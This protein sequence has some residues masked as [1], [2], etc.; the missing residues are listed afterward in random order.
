[1]STR[2]APANVRGILVVSLA[3][4]A[5][6][7]S[8]AILMRDRP[9]TSRL[10]EDAPGFSI[11][12][13]DDLNFQI[14]RGGKPVFKLTDGFRARMLC[15]PSNNHW[16]G[17]RRTPV[18]L[19]WAPWDAPEVT[20]VH[21]DREIHP[22]RFHLRITGVKPQIDKA[23]FSTDVIALHDTTTGRISYG[24]ASNLDATADRVRQVLGANQIEY[25]DPWIEGIFW[26]ERDGHDRE[27][28]QS[29]VF[30][31]ANAQTL[32]R[33]PKLHLFP[34]L[35]GATYETLVSPMTTGALAVVDKSEPGIRFLVADLTGPGTLG[36][37]WWTW[38]PHFFVDLSKA[39]GNQISYSMKIEEIPVKTGARMLADAKPIPFES[40]PDYQVPAFTRDRV[41]RFDDMLDEPGEWSWEPYSRACSIDR[42]LGYDDDVSVTIHGEPGKTTAW[43]TRSLGYDYFDHS[44]LTGQQAV[45]AMVRTKDVD[46]VS[47]IG[48]VCYNGAES[49]LYDEPDPVFAWSDPVTGTSDWQK[50]TVRFDAKGFKRFKIVLEQTGEGV[51]WFDNVVLRPDSSA[52]DIDWQKG[53][54]DWHDRDWTGA[55]DVPFRAFRCNQPKIL[56]DANR[57][58][59]AW[60]DSTATSPR[61]RIPKGRYRL[62]VKAEGEGCRDDLPVL[63]LRIADTSATHPIAIDGLSEI[64]TPFSSDGEAPVEFSLRFA[65]DGPCHNDKAQADKTISVVGVSIERAP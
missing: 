17:T 36:I 19:G 22:N 6:V 46:N 35:R 38:D 48:V 20:D 39:S 13:T 2:R 24:I 54:V 16:I 26:P 43:Y 55:Q 21:V 32:K 15:N 23:A 30:F 14:L 51:S 44:L 59:M 63:E 11:D 5:A 28:Y 47:R 64:T 4:A 42:T 29:F 18:H 45:T 33:A 52:S 7:V 61:F 12:L 65:N 60:K 53:I 27:L 62:R 57:L 49:W 1:M 56:A 10:T 8:T 50:R 40:D 41:N 37:C 31:D 58:I 3:A 25:L 9:G 34:S